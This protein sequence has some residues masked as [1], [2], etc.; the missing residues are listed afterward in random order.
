MTLNELNA[1]TP[2]QAYQYFEQACAA[3]KL[4]FSDG[5]GSPLLQPCAY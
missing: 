4:G 3:K 2:S 5:R 1:L